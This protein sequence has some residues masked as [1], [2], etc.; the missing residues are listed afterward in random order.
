MRQWKEWEG[1]RVDE[2]EGWVGL[3]RLARSRVNVPRFQGDLFD[4]VLGERVVKL[5]EGVLPLRG[6]LVP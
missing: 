2:W 1:G 5:G 4:P 6:H 3:I